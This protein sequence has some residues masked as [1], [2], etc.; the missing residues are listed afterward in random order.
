MPNGLEWVSM[1]TSQ[2]AVKVDAGELSYRNRNLAPLGRDEGRAGDVDPVGALAVDVGQPDDHM[3]LVAGLGA[4]PDLEV[5]LGVHVVSVRLVVF[6]E[7]EAK[8]AAVV[9]GGPVELDLE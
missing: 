1:S 6:G 8:C 4:D 3:G 2:M 5:G 9:V 7:V